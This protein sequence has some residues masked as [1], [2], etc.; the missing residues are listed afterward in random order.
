MSE[1]PGD[2]EA[3]SRDEGESAAAT[4]NKVPEPE[5]VP[6]KPASEAK[7]SSAKSSGASDD[8]GSASSAGAGAGAG[9]GA[10]GDGRG[11]KRKAE[12]KPER[13]LAKPTVPDVY[14][15]LM[16]IPITKR[17]LF[18]GFYKAITVRDRNVI[19]AIAE[20]IKRGQP[21]VGAFLMKDDKSDK[22]TFESA[23]EVHDIGV[24]CQITSKFDPGSDPN[25]QT[26]VL[27][28][29]RKI[30]LSGLLS[31]PRAS[32]APDESAPAT[33]T[34]DA[35]PDAAADASPPAPR[36]EEAERERKGDVV[37]SFEEG[38][39]DAQQPNSPFSPSAFLSDFAVSVVQVENSEQELHDRKDPEVGALVNEIINVFREIAQTNQLF[40]DQVASFQISGGGVGNP[41]EDPSKLADLTAAVC[42]GAPEE[43]Q[44]I[45]AETDIRK[46]LYGALTV[47]KKELSGA[48][49]QKKL[50]TE[51]EN[52]IHEKQRKYFLMEQLKA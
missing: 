28:P 7:S 46:K 27:Y 8:Q 30:K 47:V 11:K 12:P 23:D 29:H 44:A 48:Q 24:F 41:A 10:G 13:A 14:P 32:A 51:V 35:T 31:A 33:A 3:P 37:A 18:P 1:K 36:E 2:E 6:S 34:L 42:Q 40:R 26:I 43:L 38:T 52:S 4:S 9:S 15:Q 21:Y 25:G 49:L 22:D 16:A 17:P 19:A 20:M 5:P 45:L 39:Q 50:A